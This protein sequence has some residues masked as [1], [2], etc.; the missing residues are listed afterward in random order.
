MQGSRRAYTCVVET[1]ESGW[2]PDEE[3]IEK[4]QIHG[5]QRSTCGQNCNSIILFR[6][7]FIPRNV[8]THIR[9]NCKMQ[10]T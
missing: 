2:D 5:T 7:Y 6:I 3:R 9:Q 8:K 1:R 10:R 4:R